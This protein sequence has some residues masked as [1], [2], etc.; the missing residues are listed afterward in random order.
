MKPPTKPAPAR[1]T[2]AARATPRRLTLLA[3]LLAQLII[4]PVHAQSGSDAPTAPAGIRIVTDGHPQ[5][6][7]DLIFSLSLEHNETLRTLQLDDDTQTNLIERFARTPGAN[8]RQTLRLTPP[9]D[10]DLLSGHTTTL[11]L[12]IERNNDPGKE[13]NPGQETRPAEGQG[14]RPATRE[15]R[16]PLN[17][18]PPDTLSETLTLRQ[19]IPDDATTYTPQLPLRSAGNARLLAIADADG[20]WPHRLRDNGDTLHAEGER[21]LA[22]P[23]KNPPDAAAALG[24]AI[25]RELTPSGQRLIQPI[26]LQPLP[27]AA[28]TADLDLFPESGS[29]TPRF[30]LP[31]AW[32]LDTEIRSLH[33]A[34][35]R[36]DP[37]R[38]F[39][40][41]RLDN[42]DL[43]L[44]A[45]QTDA[46]DP[47]TLATPP[48]A[49]PLYLTL[50]RRLAG[51]TVTQTLRLLPAAQ[52]TSFAPAAADQRSYRIL[53]GENVAGTPAAATASPA[54]NAPVVPGAPA[55][56]KAQPL[57]ATPLSPLASLS[58]PTASPRALPTTRDLS[59]DLTQYQ[60]DALGNRTRITDP[61]ARSTQMAW[62][63][64]RRPESLTQTAPEA[65]SSAPV[66]RFTYDARDQ[67]IRLTDARHLTTTTTVDGL[68][69]TSALDSPDTGHSPSTHD[70]AGNLIRLTDARGQT[71]THS[72]DAANRLTRLAYPGASGKQLARVDFVYD[73]GENSKGQLTRV[74]EYDASGKLLLSLNYRYHA[75]GRLLDET[76][77]LPTA[78]G[79]TL[80]STQSYTWHPGGA[81]ASHTLP[82]GRRIDYSWNNGQLTALNLTAPGGAPQNI[83]SNIRY[84]PFGGLKA[85]T[86]SN[87]Q[88]LLRTIDTRGRPGD[89][90][91]GH[92][93]RRLEHDPA[94]RLT[95][96]ND[97]AD[98]SRNA[99]YTY[100]AL[101]RLTGSTQGNRSQTWRYDLTGNRLARSRNDGSSPQSESIDI[102]P[103]SN[104]IQ[105]RT[106]DNGSPHPHQYDAAGNLLDD[107]QR[108]LD[109]DARGRLIQ[110]IL[111][112]GTSLYQIDTFGR[113]VRKKTERGEIIFHYDLSGH[114]I[115]ESRP[116]GTPLREIIYLHDTPVAVLIGGAS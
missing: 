39:R 86:L 7:D 108:R 88:T 8:G 64:H 71:R 66:T 95:G 50:E 112:S 23:G 116:D 87:G 94:D 43:R 114:L 48:L 49:T 24:L 59:G 76:R 1:Q 44:S 2:P 6:P 109:Y 58:P 107:G 45:R 47:A 83:A 93:T 68:G 65:G 67:L 85:Y 34:G 30:I 26:S 22:L 13:Q 105:R 18:L 27:L 100:D 51:Q 97:P 80:I 9:I 70:A 12:T 53:P 16:I 72:H 61:L 81:L 102:D 11:H 10:F 90:T 28:F 82:S 20:L 38:F 78:A 74:S 57:P 103:A 40:V 92:S 17:I 3:G 84:H 41:E 96:I 98:P 91:F 21:A 15:I 77:H 69:Q 25:V 62:D 37:D 115:G 111:G 5:S 32:N 60:Y 89:Y 75:D 104:R 113:R 55:A 63:A 29:A 33:N 54:P 110:A 4:P 79:T 99:T 101:D 46:T 56:G 106:P 42:G 73:E 52:A 19:A 36:I 35:H 31:G 14:S